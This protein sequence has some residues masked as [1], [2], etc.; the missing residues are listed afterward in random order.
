MGKDKKKSKKEKRRSR[1]PAS[2]DDARRA[3]KAAR[4]VR[5]CSGVGVRAAGAAGAVGVEAAASRRGGRRWVL[6]LAAGVAIGGVRCM[7]RTGLAQSAGRR[8]PAR[9]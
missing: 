2:D 5:Q 7:A 3:E 9:R 6:V 1:S 4:L 8:W